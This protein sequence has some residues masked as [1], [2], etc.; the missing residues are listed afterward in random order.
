V[1][2]VP[3]SGSAL[4]AEA[5][6]ASG[7]SRKDAVAL[8]AGFRSGGAGAVAGASACANSSSA[9]GG[10][11]PG[12]D[13]QGG[14]RL[15][16]WVGL[17]SLAHA[18]DRLAIAAAYGAASELEH[19]LRVWVVACMEAG[20]SG[21]VRALANRLLEQAEVATGGGGGGGGSGGGGGGDVATWM[22]T[23][24]AFGA[25]EAQCRDS[26]HSARAR[27]LLTD[28]VVPSAGACAATPPGLLQELC[29]AAGISTGMGLQGV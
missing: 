29:A 16:R 23:D 27:A 9:Y 26:A 11:G 2:R 20:Q 12:V 24:V 18:E 15:A 8:S 28:V 10:G 25:L 7:Y 19:W 21:K 14:H 22:M 3:S 6:V 1:G 5:L 4:A 17:V 13:S